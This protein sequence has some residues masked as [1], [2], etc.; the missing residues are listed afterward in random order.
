M[1]S[2]ALVVPRAHAEAAR[3][4]LRERGWLRPDLEVS[5]TELTVSF[6]IVDAAN[7]LAADGTIEVGEFRPTRVAPRSYREGVRGLNAEERSHLPRAFD[8]VGDVVLIRLPP[9]LAARGPEVG[10]A[11]LQFVPG[12]RKVGWDQGVHGPER[13]RKLVA[14]AGQG[15]WATRHRE[16]GLEIDVDPEVAYF[17]PRLAREHARV[18]DLVRPGERVFDVCCGVGPF[19]LTIARDGNA[20]TVIGIDV[21]PAAIA[22]LRS[23]AQRLGF[24][25]RIRA[26]VADLTDFLP[27]AGTADRVIFNLPREGIKYLTSV[28]EA[29]GRGG[30][31]HFYEVIDR[32]AAE[33]RPG[34]LIATVGGPETWSAEASR[35]VHPYSPSSDLVAQTLHRRTASA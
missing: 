33:R 1:K 2:R 11:L 17:S 29:V 7:P 10:E 6:P 22:L 12:A 18:A 13:L 25:D 24:T 5:R 28:S 3:S 14:L 9:D 21:N 34:E 26:E 32:S 30:T 16:N 8:V 23:N 20:A 27:H 31:L 19:A 15:A 35:V 4:R